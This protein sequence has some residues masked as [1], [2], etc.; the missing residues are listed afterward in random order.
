MEGLGIVANVIAVVDLSVKV[1]GLCAQYAQDVKHAKDDK[2]R[3][4]QEATRL[5]I[6]SQNARDLLS[7][8]QSARLKASNKLL[9]AMIDTESQLQQ[10][11]QLL[12]SGQST[13]TTKACFDALKW[14]FK[15]KDVDAIT[16]DLRRCSDDISSALQV[17][18]T[19]LILD[20]D[21]RMALDRLP[22]S[23]GASY[24]SHAEEHNPTCLQNTRVDLLQYVS[25]WADDPS[26]KPVFWLNGM[27]GTGKS[28]IS[29]TVAGNFAR[30]GH[31]GAS[32]FKK[33][34]ADRGNLSK[35]PTTIAAQLVERMPAVAPHVKA[36]IDADPNIFGKRV[37]EQFDKLVVGPLSKIS[38][39]T[40]EVGSFVV[41][42]D[43]LDECDRDEDVELIIQLF[44]HTTLQSLQLRVFVTSRP[45]L[46]IRLGF[47][48]IEGT[49]QDVILH[50][51]PAHIIEHDILLTSRKSSRKLGPSS[52]HLYLQ[53]GTWNQAGLAKGAPRIS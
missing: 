28:T 37:R 36:A 22:I 53:N 41:I 45:E 32:F 43:A 5:N 44:S 40:T 25:Q 1:I 14:P 34:E 50:D 48:A 30:S 27:A 13:T 35:F 51:I 16:K 20:I 29:R 46:P 9:H 17:D 52:M 39:D 49:Y 21:Q 3:L 2:A 42:V 33:G 24:D 47:N 11:E 31:L 19:T 18:Q 23:E 12:A 4:S 38:H 26:A 7:D 15:R 6:A 10:L 8:S